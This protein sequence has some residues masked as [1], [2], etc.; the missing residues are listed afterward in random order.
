MPHIFVGTYHGAN[1]SEQIAG[2]DQGTA[3]GH[4]VIND[5]CA[6]T[7]LDGGARDAQ[8]VAALGIGPLVLLEVLGA[9]HGIW[10]FAL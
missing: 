10:Q 9:R 3:G 4:Q 5:Q 1:R 2:S 8:L 7:G 6:G